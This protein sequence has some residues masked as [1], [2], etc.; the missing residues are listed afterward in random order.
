M[1]VASVKKVAN[2]AVK[3][4]SDAG[5][6]ISGS[7]ATAIVVEAKKGGVTAGE[8]KVVADFFQRA[9]LSAG[10]RTTFSDF[11]GTKPADLSLGLMPKP[12]AVLGGKTFSLKPG[13]SLV[14]EAEGNQIN[15]MGGLTAAGLQLSQDWLSGPA[16]MGGDVRYRYTVTLPQD[17]AVG[18]R[19]SLKSNPAFQS[20]NNP[21]YAFTFEIVAG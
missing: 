5:K 20:R 16:S 10:A 7:E 1:S 15:N 18:T 11:L 6:Q 21:N 3:T 17:T 2:N 19:F 8:R 14:F 13:Q 12:G 4:S 9:N